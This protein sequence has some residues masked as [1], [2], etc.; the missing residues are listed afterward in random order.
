MP[1]VLAAYDLVCG[2]LRFTILISAAAGLISSFPPCCLPLVPGYLSYGA[3]MDSAENSEGNVERAVPAPDAGRVR[4]RLPAA[5]AQPAV[6][7]S[8]RRRMLL[9]GDLFVAG[10]PPSS[11]VMAP[12]SV[13]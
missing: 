8:V 12:R 5:L 10:S 4:R 11:P 13:R 7:R 1:P 9:G 3:R 6:Q 2:P